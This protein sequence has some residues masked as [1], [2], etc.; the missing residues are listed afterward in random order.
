VTEK[1]SLE[2]LSLP[3]S[4]IMQPGDAEKII[5]LIISFRP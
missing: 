4:Q 3:I 2:I 5:E 1:I